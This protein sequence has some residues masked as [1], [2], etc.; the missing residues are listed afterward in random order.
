M[1]PAFKSHPALWIS[2][3][4][5]AIASAAMARI[6]I[7]HTVE[8]VGNVA[9]TWHIEPNHN[10]K[11][12]VPARAWVAL[13]R[14]GGALIPLDQATCQMAVFREPRKP[15]DKPILQPTLKAVAADQ[16]QG[17]PGADITFPKVGIYEL[18][19]SCTPKT[20]NA[21]QPFR[22]QYEVTVAR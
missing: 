6:A 10:P 3:L 22:M 12:G 15:N 16:Y 5:T 13:T 17:V 14:K 9:G 11:A 1:A 20:K 8:V 21:F 2:V 18:E 7:A 19:L 4:L